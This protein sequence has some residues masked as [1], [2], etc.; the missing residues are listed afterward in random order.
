MARSSAGE[1]LRRLPIVS[2]SVERR[3]QAKV[4]LTA[5]PISRLAGARYISSHAGPLAG[6]SACAPGAFCALRGIVASSRNGRA[7]ATLTRRRIGFGPPVALSVLQHVRFV[8]TGLWSGACKT[9]VTEPCNA[10]TTCR[11][12][13]VSGKTGDVVARV[14]PMKVRACVLGI[15]IASA[16]TLPVGAGEPITLKV[17][18]AVAFAPANLV[19]RAIVEANAANRAI[20]IVAE[21][22]D[23]Y[24]SSE[25]QLEGEKAAQ[26]STF[27][28]RSLPPGTYEVRARLLG[29]NGQARA[30]MR[31]Q[32]NVMASGAWDR[33]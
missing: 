13:E 21:S 23:F 12:S 10:A 32:V 7:T 30:S 5:S 28:F 22:T 8:A 26:T 27:E 11:R 3:S 18:P 6:G 17:S 31:H 33:D 14:S 25:M 1:P 20:E 4:L 24:R 29:A 15:L 9:C 2:V 16:A 19:V